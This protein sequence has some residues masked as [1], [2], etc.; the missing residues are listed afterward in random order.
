MKSIKKVAS[1]AVVISAASACTMSRG[2]SQPQSTTPENRQIYVFES[3]AGGFNTKTI[4]YDNGTEVIA[5]DAQF[6]PGLA[7]QAI[8][9]LRTKSANPITYLV[10]THPNPDKFNGLG[11]FKYEGAKIIASKATATAM[12]GVH[13]Y[14][15]N[16]FVNIAN[17]FT[18]ENYPALGTVDITFDDK[19]DLQ[20]DNGER[21]NLSELSGPGVSSTQTVAYIRSVNA[22]VVGDLIHHNAHAWLEGGVVDGKPMPTI[23]SWIK[24]VEELST[25]FGEQNPK[26]Y[27]GR[28]DAVRLSE[29]GPAQAAYL[30]KADQIV[31]DYAASLGERRAELT[32]AESQ[33]HYANIQKAF[34]QAFP[35]YTLPYMIQFGV[36]GLALSK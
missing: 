23:S 13:A 16:F 15:K 5:F 17:M 6:T 22:L 25:K 11:A 21:L 34:E 26:V 33:A 7:E 8:A 27:G 2:D 31:S 28:G 18:N 30:R 12:P 24:N 3:D 1:T 4:F 29:A 32:G 19:H 36:Y 35:S 14:K 10:I 20:L 9:F